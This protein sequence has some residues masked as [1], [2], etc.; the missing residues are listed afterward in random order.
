MGGII[1]NKITWGDWLS[2]IVIFVA[3]TA[4]VDF[5]MWIVALAK[6]N[7]IYDLEKTGRMYHFYH[8]KRFLRIIPQ[9]IVLAWVFVLVTSWLQTIEGYK[10]A[11]DFG[12]VMCPKGCIAESEE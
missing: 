9:C 11:F 2:L 10:T 7:L 12:D 6:P 5:L 4:F 1:G 3:S 8:Y